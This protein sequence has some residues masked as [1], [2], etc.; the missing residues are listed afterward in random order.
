MS[1]S[2]SEWRRKLIYTAL[3]LWSSVESDNLEGTETA[4]NYHHGGSKGI[5]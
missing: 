2:R 3:R 4:E 5:Y 1:K